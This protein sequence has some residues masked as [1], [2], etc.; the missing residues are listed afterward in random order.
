[1]VYEV[2][3][4]E[5]KGHTL[6]IICKGD[7]ILFVAK[8]L[9]EILGIKDV[10]SSVKSVLNEEMYK[11]EKIPLILPSKKVIPHRMLFVTEQGVYTLLLRSSKP[12]ALEFRQQ[13][14][15]EIIPS[16][17]HGE[18]FSSSNYPALS[19]FEESMQN[20]VIRSRNVEVKIPATNQNVKLIIIS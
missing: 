12:E 10:K 14:I 17:M 9:G 18:K 5:F 13:V 1:M 8:D 6:R 16:V 20:I 19:H 11:V 7:E 4:F 2:E 3:F 15:E